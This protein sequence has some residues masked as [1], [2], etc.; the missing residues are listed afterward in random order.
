MFDFEEKNNEKPIVENPVIKESPKPRLALDTQ[1]TPLD[2]IITNVSGSKWVI[3]YYRQY[4]TKDMQPTPLDLERDPVNQQYLKINNLE[5]RVEQALSPQ[6]DEQTKEFIMTGT[7][8]VFPG[9]VPIKGDMFIANTGDGQY[10]LFTV[11]RTNRLSNTLDSLYDIEY[12]AVSTLYEEYLT[13]L[14]AKTSKET[15]FNKDFISIGK[16]PLLSLSQDATYSEALAKLDQVS[17]YYFNTFFD[18]RFDCFTIPSLEDDTAIDPFLNEFILKIIA[19]RDFPQYNKVQLLNKNSVV[20][21]NTYTILDYLLHSDVNVSIASYVNIVDL[22]RVPADRFQYYSK[23]IETSGID[24]LVSVEKTGQSDSMGLQWVTEPEVSLQMMTNNLITAMDFKE[25]QYS[26]T[27]EITHPIIEGRYIFSDSFY[28]K[29]YGTMSI[30]EKMV[31]NAINGK[32]IG[33]TSVITMMDYLLAQGSQLE[34][35]YF[36]PI[37]Y[38]LLERSLSELV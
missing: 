35:H 37:T 2:S 24:Y 31:T 7:A 28:N 6:Q 14:N 38:R 16:N 17:R 12:K 25:Q 4:L 13:N 1:H 10:T 29:D 15:V 18:I 20:P 9:M 26:S 11:T 33:P 3:E 23:G 32:E 5:V 22:H 19:K 8:T 27:L 36:L 34:Q 30:I 21:N